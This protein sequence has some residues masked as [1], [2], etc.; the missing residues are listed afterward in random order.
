MPQFNPEIIVPDYTE[1]EQELALDL[2]DFKTSARVRRRRDFGEGYDPRYVLEEVVRDTA[3]VDCN[4]SSE[5]FALDMHRRDIE[6]PLSPFYV[7]LRNLPGALNLMI[8]MGIHQIRGLPEHQVCTGI[9]NA[10]VPIMQKYEHNFR[11]PFVDILEKYEVEGQAFMRARQDAPKGE[12]R[13]L[14]IGDD[15]RTTSFTK[16]NAVRVARELDY[17]P[18]VAVAI[19]REQ[20]SPADLDRIDYPFFRIFGINDLL[21][22]YLYHRRINWG[23][24]RR[25]RSYLGKEV[26]P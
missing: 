11:V 6:A 13:V 24:Y 7:N 12:G 23:Q 3:T 5:E 25:I 14:L 18:I 8:A 19:D 16:D 17:D 15:V 20:L 2:T 1:F 21:D 10:G 22:F 9:P 4:A 26:Q